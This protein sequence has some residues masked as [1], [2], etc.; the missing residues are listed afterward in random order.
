MCIRIVLSN[1][2]GGTGKTT[3]SVNLATELAILGYRVLLIDLDSQAH[4]SEGLG[5]KEKPVSTVHQVLAGEAADLS[6]C[7]Q[8][9]Q[10]NNLHLC[11]GDSGFHHYRVKEDPFILRDALTQL[12][13]QQSFDIILIDTPPSLDQ[14]MMNALMAAHWVIV[15]FIPHHLSLQGIKQLVKL[16]YQIKMSGNSKL[17]LKGFLPTMANAIVKHHRAILEQV[18]QQFGEQR[19]LPA[20][21][22]DIQLAAAFSAGQP[23]RQ[24]APQSRAAEDFKKLAGLI[25]QQLQ[26]A[27]LPDQPS[28]VKAESA[29]DSRSVA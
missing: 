3:I 9:T 11:P 12:E 23:V 13:Q 19:L 25:D 18:I 6:T 1:R 22:T 4:C 27:L 2:K 8:A 26:S 24:F 14:L 28:I 10:Q 7:V 29:A 5:I 21:R 20:L 15:P 16:L 17:Q